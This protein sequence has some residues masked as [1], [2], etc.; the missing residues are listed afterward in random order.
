[1]YNL[2]P[3]AYN[4]FTFPQLI[5]LKGNVEM[6]EEAYQIQN[7]RSCHVALEAPLQIFLTITMI[8]LGKLNASPSTLNTTYFNIDLTW[9]PIVSTSVSVLTIMA[10]FFKTSHVFEYKRGF[11]FFILIPI[12]CFRMITLQ[13]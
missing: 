4:K 7:I 9:L 6:K 3:G 5:I 8:S 13:G 2:Q 12:F 1:M 11:G 10:S